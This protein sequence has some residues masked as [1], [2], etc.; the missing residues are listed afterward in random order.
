M[1]SITLFFILSLFVATIS[2]AQTVTDLSGTWEFEIDRNDVGKSEN[3]QSRPLAE[4]IVLP[5]S[6]PQRLKGDDISVK[7]QWVGS[8]YDSS[9]F[10]NPYLKK[11]RQPGGEKPEPA[12]SYHER[13]DPVWI[14]IRPCMTQA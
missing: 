13:R 14:G 11:Y 2:P 8:L 9:Y 12:G 4:N 5:A 7:T 10:H 6:M 1:R 3:W